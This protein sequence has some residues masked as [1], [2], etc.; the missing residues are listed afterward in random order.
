MDEHAVTTR[1]DFEYWLASLDDFLEQ[2]IDAFP[3]EDRHQL[4]FSP[5]SLDVVE[6]WVLRKYPDF[7]DIV[8]PS[9][10]QTVNGV[11]CYVGEVY[12]KQL[13]AKWVIHLDDPSYAYYGLPILVWG[14]EVE[15]PLSVVT[16]SADRRT[17]DFMRSLLE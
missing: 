3:E 4:D 5:K 9:E 7:D 15:C 10:S 6:A 11:A 2:F 1:E 12:R 14:K 13:D 17:G 8:K 16:A